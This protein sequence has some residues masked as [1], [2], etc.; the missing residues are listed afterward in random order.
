MKS[1]WWEIQVRQTTLVPL[2]VNL[3]E[4]QWILTNATKNKV[5]DIG[6]HRLKCYK[7]FRKLRNVCFKPHQ[8]L[9]EGR[10]KRSAQHYSKKYKK[11]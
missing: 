10:W 6:S 9:L 3:Q 4:H 11:K 8:C 2:V 5:S 7:L 1:Y